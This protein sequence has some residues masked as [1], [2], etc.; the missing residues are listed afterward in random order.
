M[1]QSRHIASVITSSYR[2]WND[3]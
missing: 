2:L 1:V 3:L